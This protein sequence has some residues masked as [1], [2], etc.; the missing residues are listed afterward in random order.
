MAS[1]TAGGHEDVYTPIGS[2]HFRLRPFFD[3]IECTAYFCR[4]QFADTVLGYGYIFKP[5]VDK[6]PD[7]IVERANEQATR[8]IQAL[9]KL[10]I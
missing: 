3:N 5:E 1:V 8:L 10:M 4:M 7:V 2:N 6:S 9:D